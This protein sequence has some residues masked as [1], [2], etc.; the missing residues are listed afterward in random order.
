MHAANTLEGKWD[1][2]VYY[3][4]MSHKQL[5]QL[6]QVIVEKYGEAKLVGWKNQESVFKREVL[7]QKCHGTL[8]NP[9]D[10]PRPKGMSREPI[11]WHTI[12]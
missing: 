11:T 1:L 6:E 3:H 10:L 8:V 9:Y 2:A 5:E 4:P 7:D 12:C